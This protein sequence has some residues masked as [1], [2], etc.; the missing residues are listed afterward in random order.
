LFIIVVCVF[1]GCSGGDNFSF[2]ATSL[3][4]PLSITVIPGS[5][6][7]LVV[8]TNFDF[9]NSFDDPQANG[10]AIH[11]IDDNDELR[12]FRYAVP[13]SNGTP[14][15]IVFESTVDLGLGEDPFP[16]ILTSP[17]GA[18]FR[19]LYIANVLTGDLSL[20]NADSLDVIDLD[21]DD[22]K[23]EALP[24]DQFAL[25]SINFE[26]QLI[27][28]NRLVSFAT[29]DLFLISTSFSGLLYVIDAK[30]NELEAIIN[31]ESIA[32]A[33]NLN[34]IAI[35]PTKQAFIAS[36]GVGGIVV[37]D[38]SGLSDNGINA[39]EI[40]PPLV[41]TISTGSEIEDLEVSMDGSKVYAANFSR[42]SIL[43]LD[44]V[45]GFVLAETSVGQGPTELALSNDGTELLVTN[46]LS[47]SVTVLDTATDLVKA[48]IQ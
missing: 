45:T 19:K 28:P 9:A 32:G 48:T 7:A 16:I 29:D 22:S 2:D 17:V 33:P 20:I 5:D 34:G 37:L 25:G 14:I 39:E 24:L 12:I 23:S 46:F 18:A 10:G 41:Q 31:L 4:G 30:D 11:P 38:L 27:R 6:I 35:T 42:N 26:N 36:H 44:S 43:V 47:D 1:F 15:D 3:H 40:V 13:G 8:S 21:P